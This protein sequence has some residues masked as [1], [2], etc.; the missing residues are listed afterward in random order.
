M[1]RLALF[2]VHHRWIVII[3]AALFLPLAALLGGGVAK[4][5]TVGGLEDPG[6]ESAKTAE[7]I[8]A[9]SV[10]PGSRTSSSW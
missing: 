2:V 3:V 9:A 1:R 6:S 5:L 4:S 8:S 10:A 7:A